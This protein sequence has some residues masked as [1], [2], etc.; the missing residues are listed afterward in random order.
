[1]DLRHWAGV[2]S[3][4]GGR[5]LGGA[6]ANV[7]VSPPIKGASEKLFSE[8]LHDGSG[9]SKLLLHYLE[10]Y[11]FVA[12]SHFFLGLLAGRLPPLDY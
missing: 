3:E 10:L 4:L 1:M 2:W 5:W 9:C 8:L 11:L 7:F 6:G 12:K